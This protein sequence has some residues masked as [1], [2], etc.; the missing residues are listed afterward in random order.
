MSLQQFRTKFGDG[1]RPN[2]YKISGGFGSAA[3]SLS[4]DGGQFLIKSAAV[5]SAS[6]GTITVPFRG[7]EIKRAG[8]R[9]FTDWTISVLC[10]EKMQIHDSFVKWSNSFLALS[11][12]RR[13]TGTGG[14]LA[15]ADWS[16]TPQDNAG[17]DVRTFTLT[18]C[19]PIEVGT[20]DLSFDT[21]DS[22]AEFSVTIGFERWSYDGLPA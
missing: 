9:T 3:A 14:P 18:S 1:I 19:W 22:V 16:V 15:Y 13:G 6:L 21:T 5:P 8:D 10:D 17:N 4:S 12:D 20:V 11:S 7:T 2:L